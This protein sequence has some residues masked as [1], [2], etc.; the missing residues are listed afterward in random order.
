MREIYSSSI[1]LQLLH[2][3]LLSFSLCCHPHYTELFSNKLKEVRLDLIEARALQVAASQ[4]PSASDPLVSQLCALVQNQTNVIAGLSFVVD[5]LLINQQELRQEL[6][7]ANNR[8]VKPTERLP[9]NARLHGSN[10]TRQWIVPA[11]PPFKCVN[12]NDLLDKWKRSPRSREDDHLVHCIDFL[13]NY[14]IRACEPVERIQTYACRQTG[15]CGKHERLLDVPEEIVDILINC[16][17]DGFGLGHPELSMT[18][19][20]LIARPTRYWKELGPID[21]IRTAALEER[22]KARVE[23]GPQIRGALG[24]ALADVRAYVMKQDR[25]VPPQVIFLDIIQG[26]SITI[27]TPAHNIHVAPAS[28]K[29]K[30][31]EPLHEAKSQPMP[32]PPEQPQPPPVLGNN[33]P[34]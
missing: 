12:L 24:K 21:A 15:K 11:L 19:D 14:L 13:R 2:T 17:L 28:A 8:I 1:P 29:R 27:V 22:R 31:L 26:T 7:R 10:L 32:R 23:W 25:L 9:E 4:L 5:A 34:A 20:Q 6:H 30:A 18:A 3:F 33:A 16:L